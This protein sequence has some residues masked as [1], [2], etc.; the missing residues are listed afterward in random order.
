[1]ILFLLLLPFA[2]A[3]NLYNLNEL[4][5]RLDIEGDFS[6]EATKPN[7]Q[8]KE[9][10]VEL[11]LR[12]KD[13]YR[14]RVMEIDSIG[15]IQDDSITFSYEQPEPGKLTYSFTS[16]IKTTDRP[17][18]INRKLTYPV[19]GVE[20]FREYLQPTKTIDSDNI[21]IAKQAADLAE[22]KDDL[23][24]VV[25]TLAQW[26]EE[27]IQYNLSTLTADAALPASWVL[28]NRVG[29]CDEMTSLFIAMARA[30]GIPARFVKGISY[31]T[32]EY[33]DRNWLPHG[34]AEVY[35][36][37]FGWVA[38]DPTFGQYGFVDA[39]HIKLV[40]S[41]DPAMPD[42]IFETVGHNTK[43]NTGEIQPTV[44]IRKKGQAVPLATA[45]SAAPFRDHVGFGSYN[46]ITA[47]VKN[48]KDRYLATTLTLNVPQEI[49]IVGRDKKAILLK[50]DEEKDISWIIQIPPHLDER[51][52][53]TFPFIVQSERNVSVESEFTSD[54]QGIQFS[55]DELRPL[56]VEEEEKVYTKKITLTCQHTNETDYPGEIDVNCTIQNKGNKNLPRL[57]FCIERR[58]RFAD[59]LINQEFTT[60]YHANTTTAGNNKITVIA[61]SPDVEKKLF[62]DYVAY[63]KPR[64]NLSM[65]LPKKIL[66]GERFQM[67]LHLQKYSFSPPTNIVITVSGDTFRQ[68][69]TIDELTEE[70]DIIIPIDTRGFTFTEEFDV[71]LTW[72]DRHGNDYQESDSISIAIQ[73]QLFWDRIIMMLNSIF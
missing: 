55:L 16:I 49:R 20:E 17:L 4:E 50:P 51:Y 23:F 28:K 58:C 36:P 43:I 59:L 7:Y 60:D 62:L 40:E 31:T 21:F 32:S 41:A 61:S 30:L 5:V 18:E 10:H 1:M 66:Y 68:E 42:V 54:V 73:P 44:R 37:E 13:D 56:V 26:T 71:S 64:L 53:Y 57:S 14:Q 15:D 29:V 2:I 72:N 52:T 24:D 22:G 34:W 39:T 47:D 3:N 35:F 8:I 12:P 46:I 19:T 11:F 67:L 70:Q 38:F 9:S 27:N 65:T 48:L 25:F 63:D 33:F 6:I 45:F 69:V